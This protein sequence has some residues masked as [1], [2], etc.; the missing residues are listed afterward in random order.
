MMKMKVYRGT[1]E[2]GGTLLE[3][4]SKD[5]KVLFDAGYPLFLNHNPIDDNL[6]TRPYED[7]LKL[8]VLPAINGLYD[9]D[10]PV[11]FDGVVIS[12][13]HLDHYGLVKYIHPS[14][15]IYYS[16]GSKTLMDIT[17]RFVKHDDHVLNGRVFTMYKPF[18]IGNIT[19]KPYLMDHSAFDAAAFEIDCGGKTVIYTGDFRGHGRK[20]VC[21][22]RFVE[23]AKKE[24]D[25]LLTEG[26][27]LGRKDETVLT[28]EG[29]EKQI[30]GLVRE[31]NGPILFQ[32][33]SQNIDR[34][35]S[36]Y[37]VAL[38][39]KKTFVIDVY[40]ANILYELR[41][42]GNNLSY[43]SSRYANI[44]VFY[45]YGLTRKIFDAIGEEFAR[46]FSA[47][48]I[49]KEDLKKNKKAS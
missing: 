22:D 17:N 2:I 19:I 47:F 23:H 15:P 46:R 3:I 44:K 33:S 48:H 34:L 20:A 24:A 25:V 36:F 13:A 10:H 43:P 42:L 37:R 11:D 1:K 31:T 8:G 41:Q 49:S 45:P 40:T 29:L 12:H 6:S 28:E 9:W 38:R 14:I 7:L 18:E 4:A 32:T 26:S 16:A 39:L 21:L 35:V 5:T 27:M 30:L